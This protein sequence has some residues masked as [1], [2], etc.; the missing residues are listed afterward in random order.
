MCLWCADDS[1]MGSV[2]RRL[3]SEPEPG[4]RPRGAMVTRPREIVPGLLDPIQE[5]ALQPVP[6]QWP[7]DPR[8]IKRHREA[9]YQLVQ[10][11]MPP[12]GPRHG[13]GVLFLGGGQ[14]WP[15][16]VVGVK[17]LRDTGST[18]PVQIWHCGAAEPVCRGDLAGIA[19]VE[20]HD[21]TA[22]APPPRMLG[23]W[24]AKTVALIACGWERVFL[25]DADA[26]CL[27]DP[28][29]L[30][31]R[32]SITEPFL[33]WEDHPSALEKVNWSV[34]GLPGSAVPPIQGGEFAI[35]I[36]FFWR[37]LVLAHWLNQHSDFTYRHQYGDQDS[38]RVALTLT[39]GS[40][41]CLEPSQWDEIAHICD[42]DGRPLVV[43]R[44][45]AKMFYP[46]DVSSANVEW[47]NRRL[48]RLPGE[49]QA[50]SHFETLL[51][52][53]RAPEVFGHI[54]ASGL[55]GLPGA[56]GRGSTPHQ[57]RPYLDVVNGLA[58]LSGWRRII[59]LGCGDGWVAS[60]LEADE[61]VGV[62]CHGPNVE[63]LRGEF[64]G[65]Q[66]LHLDLD[67]DR[68]RL[69]V[70]DVAF[71]KDVLH[72]WPNR[73]VS[74]WLTWARTCG[75]WRWLVCTQDGHQVAE[76]Q[77]CPLGGYRGL[78]PALAPLRGLGLVPFCEYLQKKVLLLPIQT[79]VPV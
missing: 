60:R 49:V 35:H 25:L 64:P 56:S 45:W 1:D 74:D 24:E 66:W 72:H 78:D 7:Y 40:G 18:L 11:E 68:D 29:P 48:D 79:G 37:D 6:E 41:L 58:K 17:M 44:C 4:E 2:Y 63:R 54:Y 57:A 28:T 12:C 8:V 5:P 73:L 36:H 10:A 38:W 69:P 59:D 71:L 33:Y 76:D 77:D 43:H 47:T 67:C 32:L 30:L 51:A 14:Y 21:L 23:G 20:I 50:W 3:W 65:Q 70:G 46:E 55:W 15:G 39:G 26:Y 34:W 13:A 53:R 27:R 22:I 62:D 52:S 9:L 42:L 31:E 16:I 75:K 19:G 61:V